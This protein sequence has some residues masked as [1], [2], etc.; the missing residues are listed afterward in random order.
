VR[1]NNRL[2]VTAARHPR[3]YGLATVRA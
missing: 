3:V 2:L 1:I